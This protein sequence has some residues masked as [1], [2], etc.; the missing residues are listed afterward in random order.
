M[1]TKLTVVAIGQDREYGQKEM[2]TQ[3][4]QSQF[5]RRWGLA[6]RQHRRSR[7]AFERVHGLAKAKRSAHALERPLIN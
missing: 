3:L 2:T 6:D 7:K 5:L 1:A 4:A